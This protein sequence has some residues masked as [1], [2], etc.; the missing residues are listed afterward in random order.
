MG[1]G[2]I[3]SLELHLVNDKLPAL[4]GYYPSDSDTRSLFIPCLNPTA[5]VGGYVHSLSHYAD[6]I[7]WEFIDDQPIQ[8]SEFLRLDF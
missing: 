4:S 7:L 6:N 3:P 2:I 1:Y 8:L 5:Y